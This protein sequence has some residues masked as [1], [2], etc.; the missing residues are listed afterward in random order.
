MICA[1]A[2]LHET[3]DIS[4]HCLPLP[5]E[6]VGKRRDSIPGGTAQVN[7]KSNLEDVAL[8]D[9]IERLCAGSSGSRNLA[10]WVAPIAPG[11]SGPRVHP[12]ENRRKKWFAI[13]SHSATRHLRPIFALRIQR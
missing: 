12:K 7:R 2:D 3:R 5:F 10:C 6:P 4:C 1:I 8:S 9:R 11:C 13:L